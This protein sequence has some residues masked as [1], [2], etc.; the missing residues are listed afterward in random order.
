MSKNLINR[1]ATV[2]GALTACFNIIVMRST[3][4]A[5]QL[6]A[7]QAE[8]PFYPVEIPEND[9]DLT[10]VNGGLQRAKG[11]VIQVVG[12]VLNNKCRPVAGCDLVVWQANS[13]GRYAHPD[14]SGSKEPLDKNFQSDG[15][16]KAD[17]KGFYRFLTIVPGAYSAGRNWVRPPHIHF[18]IQSSHA[19]L[20]TQMYFAGNEYNESD[21]LLKSLAHSDRKTLIVPFDEVRADGIKTGRFNIILPG[22]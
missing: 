17:V 2:C 15:R 5:C 13:K 14:D 3:L 7:E 22:D 21:Y 11:E 20:T 1:R 18:K 10:K 6:T 9:W 8:G 4:A 12:Q 19:S 16:I